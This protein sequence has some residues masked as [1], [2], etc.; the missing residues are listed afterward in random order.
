[1]KSFSTAIVLRID[2]VNISRV[3]KSLNFPKLQVARL[4]G[5]DSLHASYESTD[6]CKT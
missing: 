3:L 2:S 1:M 4:Q 6:K 5:M